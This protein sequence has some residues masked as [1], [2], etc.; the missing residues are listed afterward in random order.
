MLY[1]IDLSFLTGAATGW[2]KVWRAASWA[3]LRSGD[4]FYHELS[5]STHVIFSQTSS[6]ISNKVRRIRELC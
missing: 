3:S 4:D 1:V 5:V 6:L 2:E